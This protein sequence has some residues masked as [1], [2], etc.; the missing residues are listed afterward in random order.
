M[1]ILLVHMVEYKHFQTSLSNNSCDWFSLSHLF[2]FLK[3]QNRRR[4][5]VACANSLTFWLIDSLLWVPLMWVLL[6][7]IWSIS[8][9]CRCH[10]NFWY[11][12]HALSVNVLIFFCPFLVWHF[13]SIWGCE[14]R[15]L[16]V[17]IGLSF[18]LDVYDTLSYKNP[19]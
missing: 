18:H 5:V 11:F 2:R 10:Q 7:I 3:C 6:I 12:S 19:R 4:S 13:N 17:F 1:A 15:Y 14:S 9:I 8:H 16:H